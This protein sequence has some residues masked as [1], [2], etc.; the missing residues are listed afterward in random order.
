MIQFKGS[1]FQKSV[2]LQSVYWYLRYSLS[3]RDIEELMQERGVEVDHWAIQRW[4]IKYT[5][6]LESSIRKR[7]KPVGSSW[8]MDEAYIKIKSQ[9]SNSLIKLSGTMLFLKRLTSIRVDRIVLQFKPFKSASI[10]LNGIEMVRMIKKGQ[11]QSRDE[12]AQSASE[13]FYSLAA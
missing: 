10:T 6:L 3:Y 8:R 11:I 1:H 5:P 4:V 9:R 2:I 7:K 13:I 12:S